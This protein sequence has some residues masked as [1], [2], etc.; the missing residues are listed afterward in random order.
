MAVIFDGDEAEVAHP[1]D[2]LVATADPKKGQA[3]IGSDHIEKLDEPGDV[4]A[5]VAQKV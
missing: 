3:A 2:T 1:I 4:Q 5:E